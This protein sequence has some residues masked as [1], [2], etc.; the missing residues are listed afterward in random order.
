MAKKL[1]KKDIEF[2]KKEF[3]KAYLEYFK[4][5]CLD[6]RRG[7]VYIRV[8]TND[9]L[10]YSPISQLKRILKMAL[11]NEIYIAKEH[12]FQEETGISGK[13][14]DK[15]EKFNKMLNTAKEEPKPFDV[16][17]IYNFSRF[18][19]NKE[20]SVIFKAK[21]RKNYGID[22][23][24]A[25]QPLGEGKERVILESMYEAMDEYYILN[26]AEES[27]R[28]KVEK[29]ERGEH[30]GPAPYG[31]WYDKNV[32]LIKPHA[33]EKKI[34]LYIFK[35]WVKPETT[36]CGLAKKLNEMGVKT[37]RGG[38]WCEGTVK[39]IV[40]NPIYAG[41]TRF[42]LGGMGKDWY[43]EDVKITQGKH[44]AIISLKLWAKAKVKNLEHMKTNFKYKKPKRLKVDYWLR[45][46]VKCS[47]CGRN[48]SL[49]VRHTG[50]RKGAAFYQ[51][52]GYNKKQC[53]ESHCIRQHLLEDAIL[54][55]IKENYTHKLD[56][57]IVETAPENNEV[58]I[59]IAS[60]EK[61]KNRLSRVE[62]AF[63]E[64]IDT[65]E[66]YKNYKAA[67]NDE[68]KRLNDELDYA[69][70]SKSVQAKKDKVYSLCK[71]AYDILIDEN[72][73][74][75]IKEQIANKLFDNIVYEKATNSLIITYKEVQHV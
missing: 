28:G 47:A 67:L 71:D 57:N 69:K 56:I 38:T 3:E 64:G 6:W 70:S 8:S 27:L 12:I 33:E 4:L 62:L 52:N 60:I 26:L 30:V 51:C 74:F 13:S 22:V 34:I 24:S 44:E 54:T 14:V 40:N 23:I 20:E 11:D 5:C 73:E 31:Y 50:E 46:L 18:A 37:K 35:E 43:G 10:E 39:R 48:L 63:Q 15:R 45:G 66:E 55:L 1:T 2:N 42:C 21:L 9:Q 72:V 32:K 17:L 41:F 36:I 59:I 75:V 58:N 25:T 68:L 7:A 65:L 29:A 61:C 53:N 16:V 49:A 19:R